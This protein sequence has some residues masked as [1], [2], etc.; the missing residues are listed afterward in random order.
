[1]DVFLSLAK[2]VRPGGWALLLAMVLF[3]TGVGPNA[4]AEPKTHTVVIE[5][6][7]FTPQV[8]E[9]NPGDTVIWR[10][11][12]PFP[13]NA[14]AS[15]RSFQSKEIAPDGSWKYKAVKKGTFSYMCTL[16][17]TMKASLVVK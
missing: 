17:P 8:L 9:V 12:D 7:Q 10:N 14:V 2:K 13:H 5:A 6:M 16:H 1:M 3:S 11:K 4:F 15:D